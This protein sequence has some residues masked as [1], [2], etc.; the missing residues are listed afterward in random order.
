MSDR[1]DAGGNVPR[2]ATK[3]EKEK[4]RELAVLQSSPW[5]G[6]TM[7]LSIAAANEVSALSISAAITNICE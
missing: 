5:P 4:E 1:A 6:A 3:K 7:G 2:G